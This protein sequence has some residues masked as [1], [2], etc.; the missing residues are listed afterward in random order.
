MYYEHH[1][2]FACLALDPV[3]QHFRH[4][5]MFAMHGAIACHMGTRFVC[6]FVLKE[7]LCTVVRFCEI[8]ALRNTS[9]SF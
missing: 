3:S 7:D 6:L 9:V 4:L 2:I 8:L 1:F 5:H